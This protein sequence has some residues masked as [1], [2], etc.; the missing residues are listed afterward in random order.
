M[1][2]FS[3]NPTSFFALPIPELEVVQEIPSV[4]V[5]LIPDSPTTTN[6]HPEDGQFVVSS[7]PKLSLEIE[8]LISSS[9]PE[10]PPSQ[11]KSNKINKIKTTLFFIFF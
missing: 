10:Y 5:R 4:E 2:I 1:N 3:P 9:F 11:P 8:V 7:S 6:I